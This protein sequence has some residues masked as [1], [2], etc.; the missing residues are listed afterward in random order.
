MTKVRVFV[1][2]TKHALPHRFFAKH[3]VAVVHIHHCTPFF[4]LG[5]RFFVSKCAGTYIRRMLRGAASFLLVRWFVLSKTNLCG[6]IKK[7]MHVH[8]R[9]VICFATPLG[10]AVFVPT[11]PPDK[12]D[13]GTSDLP[14]YEVHTHK[15]KKALVSL[16]YVSHK[17][18]GGNR[19][20]ISAFSP[21][22]FAST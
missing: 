4:S 11:F 14:S 5:P 16:Q 22:C 3:M 8:A 13:S 12:M 6:F 9:R 19:P 10:C 1:A 7:R 15:K 2:N 20:F 18:T 17:A 21:H